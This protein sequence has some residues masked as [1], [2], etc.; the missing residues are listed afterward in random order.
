[1]Y[2]SA[3]FIFV[4]II[5]TSVVYS[6]EPVYIGPNIVPFPQVLNTGSS[7]LAVNPNT[8]S[9][10]TDSS[11][12]ILGINIKRYQKLFFPFG[13]VK[14][15]APALNLV[16]ITKSD[17]ED[18]FL[19]ID[20]SY[21][22]VANNKQLTINANTV[23]G[24]V[25]ALETFSQLIQ[26]NPDQMSYTIPWVPM[27]ISDFP[28]FP[29]RGFMIDTGRHFLPVQFILHI[30][31]TI[32]YQKFNIL[33]WHIVD[34]QSFPVVSSTYTNL[35]QGAFNP[36]AIYSH[37][38]I[39]EVIAYAK[40]YGIRVV[41]E[42]DIPGHSAA[43]GVGYPQLIASCPSYAYNI[44][45][46][47]LNIA[48]PYTYQFIGNLFAE[49]SSL[50]IDQY[51]HTGGDEV[52]LDCWGE[53]PTIT[54]WM[55]KNNFNLV[56]AEEYF[57]NQLTTILTNLNRTK[58]VWNDP[59]QNGVNMTKDTLV[60][61]WDSASLT[62]EIVDAGYKAIVSFAYYLD[63]QVPNPEGKTHYEWQDTWQ[64]FYGADPL[65]NIT[66]ST[67]NVLGG[68]ACIWGEQVNQVSWDVRVYPRALAIGERLWSNE[69]VTDIQTALVRFTNNSCHIAQRG[70]N[71]GPLYPNYCYLPE[72][73]P[74]GQRPIMT[75]TPIEIASIL[76]KK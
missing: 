52:V 27:T 49:M 62:Q 22:I 30:I 73:I 20:E 9:I 76:K 24:A 10:T 57:E 53:D 70:V 60:Q 44:N 64:D 21:S 39:Q 25:R 6:Q 37:A 1:M 31:D 36:I 8:F 34:A 48:Q 2:K 32:A 67:A 59:Y 16:V 72:N 38:D 5:A 17:S 12:Q 11:S 51:F 50:F 18:L 15:N 26:W 42:F 7:V 65:D 54:A 28:R 19:G 55:K 68:E 45:N 3:L 63:K 29:W 41:P 40:S 46:M 69:A 71:S 66:T 33:H 58:M 43:W 47:L 35:T 61:V 23:W 14:S 75:L 56:Q 74:S 13:M 4:A